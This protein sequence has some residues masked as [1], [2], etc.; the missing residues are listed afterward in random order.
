MTHLRRHPLVVF[1]VL[2]LGATWAAWVPRAAGVSTGVLG[3]LSTWTVAVVAV[4]TAVLTGGRAA[5]ADLGARLVRWRVGWG[6]YLLVIVAPAMFSLAAAGLFVAFGGTWSQAVPGFLVGDLVLLPLFVLIATL[7][8]GL[9][10]ELGWRGFALPRL[11][12]R[13]TPWVASLVLGVLWATWHLPLIWTPG[14]L[15]DRQPFWL[16]F[17]DIAAKAIIFTWVFLRTRGSVLI[18][19]LLHATTN[20]FAVT[21]V[22]SSTGTLTL[23]LIAVGLEWALATLVLVRGR[24]G[25]FRRVGEQP[26]LAT[27]YELGTYKS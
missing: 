22:V 2:A 15:L 20:V 7:T 25:F 12:A 24:P 10:E 11:L 21:P 27:A 16:L 4:L 8:D 17:L 14:H 5:L 6:W 19:V 26:G 23:P 1:F 3:Q 9:G 13:H 18:A